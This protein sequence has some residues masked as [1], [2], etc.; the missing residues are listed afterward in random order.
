M[1]DREKRIEE[2]EVRAAESELIANLATSAEVRAYNSRL[3]E[4]LHRIAE[5]LRS[6]STH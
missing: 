4:E 6:P 3:S 2:I 1:S 5:S